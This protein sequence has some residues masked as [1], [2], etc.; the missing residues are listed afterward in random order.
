MQD[1]TGGIAVTGY[2]ATDLK[3]G[4]PIEIIGI[5]KEEKNNLILEMKE[6]RLPEEQEKKYTPDTMTCQTATTYLAHGGELVK[7]QGKIT[8]RTLTKDKKGLTALTVKD[9]D[10]GTANVIIESTVLSGTTGKNTLAAKLKAG[11][12]VRVTG[13]LHRNE[14]GE[15]VIRVRDCDEVVYIKPTKKPDTSNPRTGDPFAF[16]FFLWK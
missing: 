15:E 11:S 16:L 2:T 4:T 8:K 9:S 3:I 14:K 1:D 13:I 7:I 10:G 6:F 5:L 12:S